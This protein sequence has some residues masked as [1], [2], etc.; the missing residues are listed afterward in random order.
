MNDT[1]IIQ[2]LQEQNSLLC[3]LLAVHNK[4][5]LGFSDRPPAS[6]Q[7]VFIGRHGDSCWYFL[8]KDS[9]PIPIAH[10]A[11]TGWVVDLKFDKV[12]RRGKQ[13]YKLNLTMRTDTYVYT[14]STG[15]DT[16]AAKSLLTSLAIMSPDQLQ[17]PITL[18]V[19]PGEDESI[20]WCRIYAP[21]YIK[22]PQWQQNTD[23]R[24]I[25]QTAINNVR[26]AS[27]QG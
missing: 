17:S 27:K 2:L 21:D 13:T 26:V 9:Q 6:A 5:T 14:L 19:S 11:L 22:G 24:P 8:D 18:S 15:H 3:A 1:T 10:T 12:T 20:V 25:A 7:W 23:F 4:P 16:C